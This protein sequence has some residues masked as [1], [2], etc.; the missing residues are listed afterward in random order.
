MIKKIHQLSHAIEEIKKKYSDKILEV[1]G[2]ETDH[3]MKIEAPVLLE[4]TK[5]LKDAGFD[6][7][8]FVTAADNKNRENNNTITLVYGLFTTFGKDQLLIELDIPRDKP[9]VESV[10]S[11]W[12]GANWHEREVFDLFGVKF[13][14][15]PD[16]RRILMPDE[17]EGYP[18]R[19]DFTHENIIRRPDYY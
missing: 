18:L 15:H 16:L 5:E 7:L 1:E 10:V 13:N 8:S 4:I 9:E 6:H 3:I 2:E 17:W 11:V 19:K 14:Q 12:A